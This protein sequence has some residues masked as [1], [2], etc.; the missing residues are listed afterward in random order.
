MYKLNFMKISKIFLLFF[1]LGCAGR[2]PQMI[3]AKNIVFEPNENNEYELII[4]DPDFNRWF[5]LNA[6]PIQYYS[7]AYYE[8]KNRMYVSRWNEL[9]LSSVSNNSPFESY[10]NYEPNIDYGI[11]LNYKLFY[12]FKYVEETSGRY[13]NFRA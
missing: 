9:A 3:P 12:Y 5:T 6:R 1:L 10:I 8:N 7:K 2:Q 11:E 13:Y 4:I